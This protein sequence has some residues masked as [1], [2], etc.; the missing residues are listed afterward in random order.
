MDMVAARPIAIKVVR[1]RARSIFRVDRFRS[2]ADGFRVVN[3]TSVV[4]RFGEFATLNV[5]PGA[6]VAVSNYLD[7]PAQASPWPGDLLRVE[8]V[9]AQYNY[10]NSH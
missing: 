6:G 1:N 9:S 8:Y 7:T 2:A 4:P 5:N 3:A 10:L